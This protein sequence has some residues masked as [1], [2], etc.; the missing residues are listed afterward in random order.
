M[1]GL[2]AGDLLDFRFVDGHI[3]LIKVEPE[4]A[5]CGASENLVERHGK[6]ICSNCVREIRD[7]PSCAICGLVGAELVARHDKFVCTTCVDEMTLV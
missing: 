1:I 4:C 3:A 6:S 5:L 7:E 2:H